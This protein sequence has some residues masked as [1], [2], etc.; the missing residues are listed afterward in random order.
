MIEFSF[1]AKGVGEAKCTGKIMGDTMEITSD[2]GGGSTWSAKG[3][4][5]TPRLS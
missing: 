1:G 3:S 5:Q 2:Y 4:G